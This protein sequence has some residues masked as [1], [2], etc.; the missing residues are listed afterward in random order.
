MKHL[1][2]SQFSRSLYEEIVKKRLSKTKGFVSIML[3]FLDQLV[4]LPA[5]GLQLF[6]GYGWWKLGQKPKLLS[7]YH[8]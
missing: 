6:L 2:L 8:W 4:C 5:L 3:E 7:R 1:V